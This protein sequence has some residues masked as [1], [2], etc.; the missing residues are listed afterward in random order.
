MDPR[1]EGRELWEG[2]FGEAP[3][4]DIEEL[5][6]DAPQ[7]VADLPPYMQVPPPSDAEVDG[8]LRD[9]PDPRARRMDW[10]VLTMICMAGMGLVLMAFAYSWGRHVGAPDRRLDVQFVAATTEPAMKASCDWMGGE[11]IFTPLV[12]TWVCEDVDT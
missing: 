9:W 4:S 7:E 11:L 1:D 12:G 2:R 5:M 6:A 8:L 10:P 3:L